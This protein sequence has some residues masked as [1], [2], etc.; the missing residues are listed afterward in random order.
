[1]RLYLG[2]LLCGYPRIRK[3]GKLTNMGFAEL[4]LLAAGL[5]MDAFAVAV[6]KGLSVKQV[7]LRHVLLTGLWFGGFQ[8]LM[9]LLGYLLG[10]TFEHYITAVDHWVVFALLTLIGANM[11]REALAPEEATCGI[12][13]GDSGFHWKQML[14]MALA[15]SIDALA[16][17]ITFALLPEVN[18]PW[19]VSVIGLITFVLCAIGVRAGR[20]FGSTYSTKAGL[21]GGVVLILIGLKILLEH[22]GILA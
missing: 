15:T 10:E 4:V 16:V 2:L 21:A 12:S 19:A 6:C 11:I 7:R 18:I 9:P 1:M 14:P 8:A 17:G 22:L 13:D 20:M 3:E 5:S